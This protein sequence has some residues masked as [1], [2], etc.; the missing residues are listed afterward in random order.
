M[1]RQKCKTL[2]Q[3]LA[4]QAIVSPKRQPIGIFDNRLSVKN[5]RLSEHASAKITNSRAAKYV[6]KSLFTK[7]E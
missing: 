7:H 5:T 6:K 4:N 1:E 2:S 3:I